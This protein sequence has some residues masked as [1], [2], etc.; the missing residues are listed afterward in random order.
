MHGTGFQSPIA[1]LVQGRKGLIGRFL[2][3]DHG[4][5]LEKHAEL[6]DEYFRESFAVSSVGPQ[7]GVEKNPCAIVALGGYGRKEQ[8]IRS[9]VDVLFLFKKGIPDK[10][11]ELVREIIYPL[12]DTGLDVGHAT[13]SLKDC[14]DLASRDFEVLTSL[15]D[16][17][18]ICGISSVYSNL[19]EKCCRKVLQKQRQGYINWLL[20]KNKDR[21]HRYGDSTYL[22]EP[23]LKEGL[24]GLRDFHAMLWAGRAL[25][26]ITDPRD[27]EFLGHLS[28][29]EFVSLSEA[30][31]FIRHVRNRLHHMSGRKC[32]QLYFEYQ[33]RL[34]RALGFEAENG[35]QPVEAFLGALHK[36]MEFLK[37]QHLI[38]LGAAAEKKRKYLQKKSSRRSVSKGIELINDSLYF[39][40]PEAILHNPLLLIRIFEKSV[41]LK[42][43]LSLA[44]TRLVKEFLCLVDT[45]FQKSKSVIKSFKHI[46]AA[47]SQRFSA[48][49][50]ML[51]TGMLV[52][53]IPELKGVV[54]RIQYDEY[55]LY[56]VD[57]HLLRTV[58]ILKEL[59]D[60]EPD[61]DNAFFADIFRE[62]RNPEL[63]LWAGLMHDAGK[64]EGD[65]N[66][67][68]HAHRGADI[69]ARV[70]PRMGF[71]KEEVDSIA[72][73]VREHLF[74][75]HTA[76]RRDIHD[77]RTVV[78]CAGRFVDDDHLKMLYLLT[79]AD[80]RA[81]GP[82]AW[83]DWKAALVKELFFKIA[84]ILR[85]GELGS[86]AAADT[87]EAK[88]QAVFNLTSSM[89][90]DQRNLFF[91]QLSSR[92]L[93]YMPSR[94][95]VRHM[96]M[97][98]K[99]D[100]RP[101]VLETQTDPGADFRTVTVC[102]KDFPGLFSKIAGVFTLNTMDIL[103][104]EIYTWRNHIALDVFRLKPP[105]D[106]IREK[107]IWKRV[108]NNLEAVLKGELDLPSA[109]EKKIYSGRT[110]RKEISLMPD[111]IVFDNESSDFFSVLEVYT[112]DFP[113]FLYKI[114]HALFQC[115]LDICFAKIGTKVDQVVDVFYVRDFEGQKID[116]PDQIALIKA[117]IQGILVTGRPTS[118]GP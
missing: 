61:S 68:H 83:N 47:P 1:Q 79:V 62:V 27:L 44:A 85:G 117:F 17:R 97:Y 102:A 63:L 69:V 26:D 19:M 48:L 15:I 82:K 40:C 113:G 22:L 20:K 78:R 77:E 90:K 30:L 51:N 49:T 42:K 41:V 115:G 7:L 56:P 101:F 84:H 60:A 87:A 4:R 106:E 35:Q 18:F 74:L 109:L 57:K 76:T 72:F 116:D 6:L 55:H 98:Q 8:C 58:Q 3:G 103:S 94:D 46:L 45:K 9:D 96:D 67:E 91:D 99:L 93:L 105:A 100:P 2:K 86:P 73:L 52:A 37:R 31:S 10:A 95:I 110:A 118:S 64:G 28:H 81:T 71:S 59:R 11:K 53:L 38:F 89:S 65:P 92:Y 29:E 54:D 12:W 66:L 21:H 13:R 70:L 36:Q 50:E 33:V 107:E 23:N 16:G 75:M 111:K 104:A 14:A 5:F 25:Y 24:G 112:H 108:N 80:S 114:T 34:A 39:H 43:P 88:R 32:D